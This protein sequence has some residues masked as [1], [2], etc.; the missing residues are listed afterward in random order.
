MLDWKILAASFVALLVISAVF[1]GNFGVSDFLSD[2]IGKAGG[3]INGSP[4][5]G[6]PA[7]GDGKPVALILHPATLTLQ[8]DQPV[9]VHAGETVITGFTG[10]LAFDFT[11]LTVRLTA[12]KLSISFPI[13]QV[14][15]SSLAMKDFAVEGM[16]LEIEP[17]IATDAGS[18]DVGGFDGTAVATPEGLRLVGAVT[19][20]QVTVGDHT[21]ELV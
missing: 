9:T 13:D 15:V 18:V 8:P 20:F 6:S 3:A 11:N 16:K 17:D 21:F 12:E 1:L 10:D 19:S 14:E 7:S 2:L 4:F 5:G